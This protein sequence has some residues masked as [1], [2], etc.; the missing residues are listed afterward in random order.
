[1]N[2]DTRIIIGSVVFMSFLVVCVI[3]AV[4]AQHW[5]DKQERRRKALEI[6]RRKAELRRKKEQE[7]ADAYLLE[8]V[9]G[10]R[11]DF[12]GHSGSS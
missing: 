7:A 5:Y 1:V 2:E 8:T 10:Y 12:D 3:I 4:R 9:E 6:L 11:N